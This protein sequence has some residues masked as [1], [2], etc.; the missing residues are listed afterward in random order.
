M[1][2]RLNNKPIGIIA[3]RY[4]RPV[5]GILLG[6]TKDVNRAKSWVMM[7]EKM[8]CHV[9]RKIAAEMSK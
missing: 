2:D 1:R 3:R 4:K 5:I 6:S 7:V 9:V 8:R